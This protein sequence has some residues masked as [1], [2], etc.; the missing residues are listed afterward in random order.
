M[1][2]KSL[3]K[4]TVITTVSALTLAGCG[5]TEETIVSSN[6]R[7]EYTPL[8]SDNEQISEV[9][10]EDV[11]TV[12]DDMTPEEFA[13]SILDE[14]L[15]HIEDSE[16]YM[17]CEIWTK[18]D[19]GS[20]E[21]LDE[22]SPLYAQHFFNGLMFG[23]LGALAANGMYKS[24]NKRDGKIH[25]S[26]VNN[27]VVTPNNSAVRART[28]NSGSS[29]S[30]TNRTNSYSSGKQGFSSGGASRGGSASS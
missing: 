4:Y 5:S 30:N 29:T 15:S 6:N 22:N 23:S 18:S 26:V 1:T 14:E 8:P 16:Y 11:L 27:A 21:C 17:Q 24:M 28:N 2:K 19:D 9:S 13:D 3:V 7:N 10:Q 25:Q 12:P 20:N